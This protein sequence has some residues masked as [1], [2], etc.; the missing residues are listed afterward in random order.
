[1]T[2]RDVFVAIADPVRRAIIELL[3]IRDR[4]AGELAEAFPEISRPAVSRHLRVLRECEVVSVER[5]GREQWYQLDP[6]PLRELRSGWLAEVTDRSVR[7]L[8]ALRNTA[9]HGG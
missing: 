5:R 2:T 1:M 4:T 7:S 3:R 9:E 6:G 8:R